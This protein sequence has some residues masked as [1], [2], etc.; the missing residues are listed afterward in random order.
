MTNYHYL[1]TE[2]GQAGAG[3]AAEAAAAA[4]ERRS[5]GRLVSQLDGNW[6]PGL[7]RPRTNA[8]ISRKQRD[9]EK[10]GKKMGADFEVAAAASN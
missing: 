3:A 10:E 4:A 1:V 8:S 6:D 5:L 7:A 9:T 2:P